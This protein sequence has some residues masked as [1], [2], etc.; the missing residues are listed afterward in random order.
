MA[1]KVI[2]SS[3]IMLQYQNKVKECEEIKA[4]YEK[5]IAELREELRKVQKRQISLGQDNS[6]ITKH[7]IRLSATGFN[8]KNI[9][10][11][12]TKQLNIDVEIE[13]IKL[14]VDTIDNLPENLYKYYLQ[15]K[16]EF[17]DK[18]IMDKNFFS[19]VIYK[20]YQL[21]ENAISLQLQRA[22]ENEDEKQIS[23]CVQQLKSIYDSM[24]QCYSK[25]GINVDNE[26]T[27]EDLMEGYSTKSIDISS[28]NSG[29]NTNISE[30]F[31]KIKEVG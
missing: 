18:T 27:L 4:F 29:E 12:L 15:C 26:Q 20:K 9:Y 23:N 8:I 22:Q 16:K 11:I 30:A 6:E 19:S 1:N 17:K 7:I 31:S 28:S 10:D 3:E 2:S 25:N 24:S 5:R 14:V 21:L 13:R